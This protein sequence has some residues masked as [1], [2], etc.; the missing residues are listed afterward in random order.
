[1]ESETLTG[2]QSL[3]KGIG[4]FNVKHKTFLIPQMDRIGTHLLAGAF[5]GFSIHAKVLET[6]KGLDLG[7]EYTSGKEC[8]PC[9]ITTGDILYFLKKEKTRLGD[10]F[11][12]DDYIYF[13]PE[14][15]GPCR[16]GMYNKYQRI[17]LDSFPGLRNVRISS[18]TSR[19]D[20]S[21]DGMIGKEKVGKFRKTLYFS[22]VVG[23]ILNRLTWRIRPYERK[24]GLTD[25]FIERSMRLAAGTFE[26]QGVEN[27]FTKILD[28]LEK[29]IE[30]GK[31]IIDP[32][33]PQKPLVGIVGEIYLRSHDQANQNLISTLER[34]GAEVVN[35]SIAEWIN[36]TSYNR[37][38]DAK[39][40]F[41]LNLKMLRLRSM[42]EA[43]KKIAAFGIDFYYQ[44]FKQKQIYKHVG[45]LIDI[46]G[47]HRVAYLEK[48]L[49][50][51]DP[52]SFDVGTEACLS[53]SGMMAYA[54]SGF[55]GVVNV[56]PFTCMPGTVTLSIAKP[57]MGR[58]RVP[59][60]DAPCD[61]GLQP[62]REAAV[63]AFMFQVFQHFKRNGR[64]RKQ[65]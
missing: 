19:D 15:D 38:R 50:K 33:V 25:D 59:Y 2:F 4:T 56:Y 60:L 16:F 48:I 5:R 40:D 51:E 42:L 34:H 26:A 58:R 11:N 12:A 31:S 54:G 13:M 64:K 62:G 9:L 44:Q 43:L 14:S 20:Y 21:L 30:E 7:K 41:R 57:L 53:I 55:N 45:S 32:A 47:D 52:F 1:M 28:M 61:V 37:M 24:P 29:I 22:I 49:K 63:R 27:G 8:L 6:C 18:V 46:A 17:V 35:A 23:D 3:N 10:N 36:Y 39:I 65:I